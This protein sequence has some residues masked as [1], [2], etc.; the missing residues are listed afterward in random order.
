[1]SQKEYPGNYMDP[2]FMNDLE[3]FLATR[4]YERMQRSRELYGT[5]V[6]AISHQYEVIIVH[7]IQPHFIPGGDNSLLQEWVDWKTKLK[8]LF[9]FA[10]TI[11]TSSL[12]VGD[13]SRNIWCE[14]G[15]VLKK[16][17]VIHATGSDGDTKARTIVVRDG[18]SAYHAQKGCLEWEIKKAIVQ[19][20]TRYNELVVEE[21]VIAGFY[22]PLNKEE[23][24]DL[25]LDDV[26]H[27]LEEHGIPLYVIDGGVCY[28]AVKIGENLEKG[29]RCT[30][31][32]LCRN[33][34]T[35]SDKSRKQFREELFA[36]SPFRLEAIN[37]KEKR[38][39]R[40][41]FAG[42]ETYMEGVV[43]NNL[44]AY[45]GEEEQMECTWNNSDAFRSTVKEIK[46][47]ESI[48]HI[49]TIEWAH[50]KTKYFAFGGKLFRRIF[51][52]K[53]MEHEY[54]TDV[55]AIYEISSDR[56]MPYNPRFASGHLGSGDLLGAF[57]R[58]MTDYEHFKEE[59]AYHLYG[60]AAEAERFGDKNFS[61]RAK[62]IASKEVSYEEVS[63]F[64][65]SRIGENGRLI[66]TPEDKRFLGIT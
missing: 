34:F 48:R 8:I 53:Q 9:A 49:A 63:A 41:Y 29:T 36:D 42:K 28:T 21:P 23:R 13:S 40:A 61:C 62:G 19:R 14:M 66:I 52:R 58:A 59:Y 26:I 46:K 65:T 57:E 16:G 56:E 31:D 3:H 44:Q 15:V 18:V 5:T 1:M 17:R 27:F 64:I 38:L 25:P 12:K 60:L 11:S 6:R 22:V 50:Y 45:P 54:V 33:T 7:G 32:Y 39:L 47:G 37:E 10:P 35:L 51:P 20:S 4:G 24:G 55:G 30:L 43:R 2:D